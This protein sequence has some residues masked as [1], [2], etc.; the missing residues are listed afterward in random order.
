MD[1]VASPGV[2][3]A[4]EVPR[5][6]RGDRKR[7]LLVSYHFP[8]SP[9]VGAL[10]WAG[11]TRHLSAL[12]WD[13][14]VISGFEPVPGEVPAYGLENR[15]T[16]RS[17]L[18]SD[19]YQSLKRRL[20][21]GLPS[22]RDG[23]ERESDDATTENSGSGEG[24]MG[25][26]RRLVRRMGVLL[27]WPDE[28]RGWILRAAMRVRTSTREYNPDLILSSG[29][30]HSAHFS[31]LISGAPRRVPW[32]MDMRDPW[33][34]SNDDPLNQAVGSGPVTTHSYRL[35]ER[36][37]VRSAR[38]LVVTTPE[39]RDVLRDRYPG[40]PVEWIPNGVDLERIETPK[41]PAFP[42][43][44]LVHLGS[45]YAFRDPHP[46]LEGYRLF[47][48]SRP[49]TETSG[50][51]LRFVGNVQA[52]FRKT[53]EDF[54]DGPLRGHVELLGRRP[55]LEALE[56]LQRSSLS[57]VL[58][59]KQW[60]MV[61]A[62][63]Y[64]SVVLGI[65]T[66]V[67]TEPGSATDRAAERFGLFRVAPDDPEG[68]ARVFEAVASGGRSP[69]AETTIPVTYR[70][71]APHVDQLLRSLTSPGGGPDGMAQPLHP[72]PFDNVDVEAGNRSP[73]RT[74]RDQP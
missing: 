33:Y 46:L 51:K 28:G 58:A 25:S 7:L 35:L 2:S 60:S 66:L 23:G 54:A 38:S 6:N 17:R 45:V 19:R 18:L 48:D 72:S 1:S 61:P 36:V 63:I 56:I 44:S 62:K 50:S 15:S 32:I 65:P 4:R 43:L 55:R 14:R 70:E 49:A 74:L 9:A 30:P 11:L 71:I 21:S 53:I 41:E 8:P 42:G 34:L 31:V 13:V 57:V 22:E 5:A 47:L 20:A 27:T 24:E 59:Q 69:E 64:E 10:R 12:G 3:P 29:P 37:A 40:T 39:L 52:H 67:I 68:V 26:L 16:P 73:S